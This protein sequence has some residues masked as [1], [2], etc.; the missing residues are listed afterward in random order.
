MDNK[1]LNDWFVFLL[2]LKLV[3]FVFVANLLPLIISELYSKTEVTSGA[4]LVISKDELNE[5]ISQ[6]EGLKL[7]DNRNSKVILLPLTSFTK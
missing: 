5:T 2:G 7:V 4:A 1:F 6:L 3:S